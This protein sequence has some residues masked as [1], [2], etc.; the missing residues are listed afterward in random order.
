VSGPSP[1]PFLPL[2]D[3]DY[4]RQEVERIS[5]EEARETRGED[6]WEDVEVRAEAAEFLPIAAV[7]VERV[8]RDYD[9]MEAHDNFSLYSET[10]R[11]F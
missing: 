6:F 3:D 8:E 10:G 11:V 2:S 7:D 5:S 1:F 4:V 9:Y